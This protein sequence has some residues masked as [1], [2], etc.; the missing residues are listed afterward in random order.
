[1]IKVSI[2]IPV[3]NVE[4]YLARCLD[5]CVNQD[6][7]KNEYEIIIVNDGSP[8]GSK[9]IAEQYV[10]KYSNI[11]L[12][13][14]ENGGLS[15]ARNNGLKVAQGKYVWFVDSD[16]WIAENCL[17]EIYEKME[18]GKLD[19]LQ[20]G[21]M[22]AWDDGTIKKS[23]RGFFKGCKTGYEAMKEKYVPAPAQFTIY[24]RE[25]LMNHALEFY[26]GIYHEDAEFKPRALFFAQRFASLNKHVYYYYQR[27]Q[28]NIM[29]K[30][31][32]KRGLDM[33]TVCNNLVQFENVCAMNAEIK[34]EF[35]FI[36]T[37]YL[38]M[39][40]KGIISLDKEEQ[41]ILIDR[42]KSYSVFIFSMKN[43][44]S[45]AHRFEGWLLSINVPLG[46]RIINKLRQCC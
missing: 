40:F 8:D 14:Q 38:N 11:K 43:S 32:L 20:I 21:Y 5:S 3:Y 4:K 27:S 1:M 36:V 31:S 25:F 39:F 26:P 12:I 29:S 2:I 22:E 35:D 15:V 33:M 17:S 41:K 18:S 16:D 44:K 13:N 19:M 37:A 45:R 34:K 28:G 46:I 23:E 6:M 30:Y 24:K 10:E 42:F 9:A 7:S